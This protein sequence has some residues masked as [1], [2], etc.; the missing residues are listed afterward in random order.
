MDINPEDETS[1]T[2]QT[3]RHVWSMWRMNDAP[4]VDVCPS[5]NPKVYQA[6]ISSPEEWLLD[7]VNLLTIHMVCLA[8]M[9]STEC[10][11]LSLK[12]RPDKL[13]AQHIYWPPRGFIW[14]LHLSEHRSGRKLIW[15]LMIT[16]LTVCRLADHFRYQISL[17]GGANKGKRTQRTPISLMWHISKKHLR[18]G[19]MVASEW[20]HAVRAV[21]DTPVADHS[22]PGINSRCRV[23]YR[24]PIAV[25]PFLLALS[26]SSF[27]QTL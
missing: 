3:K 8:M 11:Q 24:P 26:V 9:K 22:A 4:N 10:Q 16:A 5:L 1:Y 13:I 17:T 14:I 19:R 25:S 15:I 21:R 12:Q 2:T 23:A 7:L 18:L 20:T 6:T 27:K